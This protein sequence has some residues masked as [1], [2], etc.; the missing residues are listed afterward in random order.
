MCA[1]CC[2]SLFTLHILLT[3]LTLRPIAAAGVEEVQLPVVYEQTSKQKAQA[4]HCQPAG[5]VNVEGE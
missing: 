5:T 2:I 3:A 1:A 4:V